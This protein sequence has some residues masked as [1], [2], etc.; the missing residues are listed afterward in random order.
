M[1]CSTCGF[2]VRCD[3]GCVGVHFSCGMRMTLSSHSNVRTTRGVCT[4]CCRRGLPDTDY[5]FTPRRRGCWTFVVRDIGAMM[6]LR[7]LI[8]LASHTIGAS[9]DV[10][11][12]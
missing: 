4:K 2:T 10:G 3:R 6:I 11:H 9:H 7:A 5:N 12:L 1:K 8:C